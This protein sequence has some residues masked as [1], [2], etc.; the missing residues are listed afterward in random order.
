MAGEVVE[1]GPEVEDYK[2]GDK[3]V[4][5]LNPRVSHRFHILFSQGPTAFYFD[6]QFVMFLY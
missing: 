5:M 6:L 4:A 3:V 2:P 1:V